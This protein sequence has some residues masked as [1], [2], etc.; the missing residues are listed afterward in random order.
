MIKRRDGLKRTKVLLRRGITVLMLITVC[1]LCACSRKD[2]SP[3]I[4]PDYIEQQTQ[5][6]EYGHDA[7]PD[8]VAKIEKHVAEETPP[9]AKQT[10][11]QS[12]ESEKPKYISPIDF[13]ALR[14][15]N[16][17]VIAWLEIPGTNISYAVCQNKLDDKYYLKHNAKGELDPKGALF[18]EYIYNVRDFSDP[19]TVIYGHNMKSGKMFGYLEEI[20]REGF[21]GHD[22]AIVYMENKEIHYKLF[23]AH[24]VNDSHLLYGRNTYTDYGYNSFLEDVVYAKSI[25]A[26][27]DRS[28]KVNTGDKL[29]VL[30]TCRSGKS[31]NRYIVVGKAME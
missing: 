31:D 21:E 12:E 2:E 17:D 22:E 1:F 11:G 9:Q 28:V 18:T 8:D 5:L 4:N 7:E 30:S 13:E 29:L 10:Q 27:T 25:E 14:K 15:D 24:P 19:V 6:A 16:P 3:P 20:F 23:S 26:V